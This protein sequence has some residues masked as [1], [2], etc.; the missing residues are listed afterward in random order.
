MA[1]RPVKHKEGELCESCGLAPKQFKGYSVAGTK[2]YRAVCGLCHK[3]DHG[4]ARKDFCEM[5]DYKPL[6]PHWVL[7]VHHRDGDK[8]NNDPDNLMTVCANCHRELTASI[9]D[10]G[11]DWEK[12][13]SWL[14]RF[15]TRT[16][17]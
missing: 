14:K 9:R 6:F 5:C 11:D 8:S 16:L 4:H 3:S 13:E 10:L 15:I 12:A 7:E 2:V 1:G 17:K